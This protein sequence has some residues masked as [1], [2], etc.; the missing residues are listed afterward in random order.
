MSVTFEGAQLEVDLLDPGSVTFVRLFRHAGMDWQPP[1]A[2]YRN[3]RAD[4]PAGREKDYAV[5][6]AAE[7]LIA[8]AVECRVLSC[9]IQDRYTYDLQRSREYGVARYEMHAPAL[10]IPLDRENKDTLGLR[11]IDAD[12]ARHR[13][14][15][16]ELFTRFGGVVHGLSWESFHRHQPGRVYALWHHHKE[17]V[18]LAVTPATPYPKLAED[19]EWL[20]ILRANPGFTA[21]AAA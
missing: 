5:L 10:F 1:P 16:H 19:A 4:P 18:S 2:Q 13:A 8:A 12:Y 21:H 20:S 17:T 9:D 7:S 3:Q 6:Y 14:A 11:G 15:A